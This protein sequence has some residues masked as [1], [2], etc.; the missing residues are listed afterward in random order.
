MSDY[1][2]SQRSLSR[3][4]G[5]DDG[6]CAVVHRAIKIT[7]VDFGVLEGL[8]SLE[9]HRELLASGASRTEHSKH[10]DG[11]AV[12]LLPYFGS[13]HK[14]HIL[15]CVPVA[16]AMAMAGT[17]EVVPLIWGATWRPLLPERIADESMADQMVEYAIRCWSEGRDPFLDAM[18]FERAN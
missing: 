7:S 1:H 2:L 16:E 3:L 15:A 18:H 6:L 13:R 10:L 11:R 12:D 8:R 14:M 4:S 9:R 5:V 17:S